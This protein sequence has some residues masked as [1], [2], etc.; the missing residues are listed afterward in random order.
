MPDSSFPRL[1]RRGFASAALTGAAVLPS[2]AQDAIPQNTAV[3]HRRGTEAETPAFGADI[4]FARHPATPAVQAFAMT[5]VRLLP[6]PFRNAQ[7]ADLAYMHR[8]PADRLAHNF[9]INA[10]LP[11]SA[12]PFGGWEKPD[13]E[14]RGHFTGHYL[15]ACGLMYSATGNEQVRA[16]GDEL[17]ADLAKCQQKLDAG[18]YLSAFPLEFFDRL[19]ARK[20]VWAPFYTI[21]KI[22]AGMLDMSQH[23]DNRQALDV[24]RGMADWVDKWTGAI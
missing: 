13:C 5:E 7:E 12:Q 21:H 15:S 22:M 17:V 16:R 4:D 18:G 23:C 20:Q 10:G 14:L 19:D 1:T 11:S 24:L 8:L 3:P 6:G 9:R 2:L